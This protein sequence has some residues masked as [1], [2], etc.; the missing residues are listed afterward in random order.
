[1][2]AGKECLLNS[3]GFSYGQPTNLAQSLSALQ[4]FMKPHVS[5][6]VFVWI[7]QKNEIAS[8]AWVFQG[9]RKEKL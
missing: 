1:M 8:L 3:F 4:F 7:V 6:L 5:N 9:K 2:P